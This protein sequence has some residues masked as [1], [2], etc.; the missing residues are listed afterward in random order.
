[1][2]V[3]GEQSVG[4][5]NKQLRNMDLM[6]DQYTRAHAADLKLCSCNR[7]GE[8][9]TV[10]PLGLRFARRETR[11]RIGCGWNLQGGSATPVSGIGTGRSGP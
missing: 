7:P 9:N 1:M 5:G 3:L 11:Y 6:P 8:S 2:K 10:L 4:G